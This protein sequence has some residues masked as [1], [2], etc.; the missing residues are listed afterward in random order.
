VRDQRRTHRLPLSRL[1]P[2]VLAAALTTGSAARAA[3]VVVGQEI[4]GSK[5][6]AEMV[7][8]ARRYDPNFCSREQADRDRAVSF[9]E[10]AIVLQPGAKINALVA[11]RIAQ[12]YAYYE[13]RT[14]GAIADPA[15]AIL[16][17]ERC[18]ELSGPRHILWAEAQAGLGSARFLTGAREEAAV[19]FRS[20]LDIDPENMEPPDWRVWSTPY[21]RVLMAR[22]L[23]KLK[24]RAKRAREKAVDS[25]YYVLVRHDGAAAVSAM[26]ETAERYHGTPV[27]NQA[28]A[29]LAKAT[30]ARGSSLYRYRGLAEALTEELEAL[31]ENP[32]VPAAVCGKGD[33]A[34]A[35]CRGREGLLRHA[36]DG[37]MAVRGE[38]AIPEV[39]PVSA[40]RKAGTEDT[41]SQS[42]W[43]ST[44]AL[45]SIGLALGAVLLTVY[46]VK[47][48]LRGTR[49]VR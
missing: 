45:R 38:P 15:R 10:Q 23:A 1:A 47:R 6:V 42:F 31:Q 35:A 49:S 25:I 16:W 11:A 39:V 37:A 30:N 13:D 17:W 3:Q 14:K 21:Q 22:E 28:A 41:V 34:A 2:F 8:Q 48:R 46:V 9:Y 44:T 26:A 43:V 24:K 19:A 12:L 20:V 40:D 4:F 5:E 18:I 32:T 7:A 36:Q 29:L 33:G 27:G